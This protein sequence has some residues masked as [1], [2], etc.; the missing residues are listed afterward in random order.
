M[1][2]LYL[3]RHGE[4]EWNRQRRTQGCGNDLSLSQNGLLQAKALANRLK[5]ISVDTIYSS[6]LK[7]AYE[8]AFEISKTI[9]LPVNTS[10]GLR[11][12]NLG[13]FEGLTFDE[14]ERQY[15]EVFEIWRS[16]PKETIIPEGEALITLQERISS[17]IDE[18]IQE[19]DG[20]N[21]IV[22]SHGISIKMLILKVLCMDISNHDRIR[23]DNAGIS[24]IEYRGNR[25]VLT[26][27]NDICHLA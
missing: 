3:I 9:E 21:I 8:T 14:I 13:C 12:M 26:L 2:R 11:E 16:N 27:L 5:N 24:I 20:K 22:V 6:D 18:I 7:R 1:T 19:H 25:P 17:E 15:K 23:L 10:P 4:T